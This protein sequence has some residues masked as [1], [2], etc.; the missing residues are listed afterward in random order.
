[1]LDYG[2][3]EDR[4]STNGS[5][6]AVQKPGLSSPEDTKET[7]K[8]E[9]ETRSVRNDFLDHLGQVMSNYVEIPEPSI[10]PIGYDERGSAV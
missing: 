1:M 7:I 5:A 2:Y 3:G 10:E 8:P 6:A 4:T 9:E